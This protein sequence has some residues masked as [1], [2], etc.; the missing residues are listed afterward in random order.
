MRVKKILIKHGAF[1]GIFLFLTGW[2]I[3][4]F[5][6]S[7]QEIVQ[8]IGVEAGYLIVFLTALVGV[9]AFTSASFFASL[10]TFASS[11]DFNPIILGLVAAPGRVVGDS[12]FFLLGFKARNVASDFK[13]K[14]VRKFSEWIDKMPPFLISL[15]VFIY[16]GFTP[17]PQDL[18]MAA[19]GLGKI[20]F[21]I[22]LPI[23]LLGN[24]VFIVLV[25]Y[26]IKG[27]F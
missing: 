6:I 23:A 27:G 7:P 10:I 2:G 26:F 3:L 16:T 9:S 13:I 19:L 14:I 4:L 5:F 21:R 12:L 22:V 17:L 18:L 11:G 15:V 24:A 25:A 1:I 20:S 8:I